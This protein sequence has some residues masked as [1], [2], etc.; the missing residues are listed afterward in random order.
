MLVQLRNAGLFQQGL[1]VGTLAY[2]AWLNEL[3]AK[4]V[5]ASTQDISL[6]RRHHLKLAA[7]QSF[8][9][10]V[11]ATRLKF[12]AVPGTPDGTPDGTRNGTPST[13]GKLPGAEGLR[14]D[15]LAHGT[16][17]GGVVPVP[18][19]QWALCFGQVVQH[20]G[21]GLAQQ[22]QQR[23]QQFVAQCVLQAPEPGYE[24]IHPL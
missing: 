12:F 22:P 19:L 18:E 23:R 4:A 1:V 8:L 14:V 11:Q 17:L 20:A 3:G 21:C 13:S 15:M 9:Q 10:T 24:G 5:V 7:P 16:Q 2:M 6:A